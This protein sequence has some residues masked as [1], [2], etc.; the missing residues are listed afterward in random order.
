MVGFVQREFDHMNL[1]T[2]IS[3]LDKRT[4]LGAGAAGVAGT[5]VGILLLLAGAP[6]PGAPFVPGA[7]SGLDSIHQWVTY[8]DTIPAKG[9][10]QRFTWADVQGSAGSWNFSDI[11][12]WLDTCKAHGVTCGVGMAPATLN[13]AGTPTFL[14]APGSI[15]NPIGV[16]GRYY[17]NYVDADVKV[18]W[19]GMIDALG[20]AIRHHAGLGWVEIS[21][22]VEGEPNAWAPHCST[23][24]SAYVAAMTIS[25]WRTYAQNTMLHYK[26]ALHGYAILEQKSACQ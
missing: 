21:I 26:S 11:I 10:Y 6:A 18:Q 12:S 1:R 3:N 5:L 14:L 7:Y 25:Q 23:V 19:Y 8:S 20:P 2:R 13:L 9:A 24:E 15:Y 22:G 4:K 16:S 17:L